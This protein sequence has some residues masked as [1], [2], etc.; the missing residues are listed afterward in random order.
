MPRLNNFFDDFCFEQKEI[1]F[2]HEFGPLWIRSDNLCDGRA[3]CDSRPTHTKKKIPCTNRSGSFINRSKE[4]LRMKES[5]RSGLKGTGWDERIF[6]FNGRKKRRFLS[7]KM[8][9]NALINEP[10][11][12]IFSIPPFSFSF[13]FLVHCK[14]S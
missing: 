3:V 4:I 11:R 12:D 6:F 8:K 7:E 13:P 1:E 14:G 2:F 9:K 5:C 10:P